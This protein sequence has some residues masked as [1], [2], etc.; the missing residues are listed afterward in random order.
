MVKNN[1][2]TNK[3]NLHVVQIASGD[4]WAG[5]EVM[6]YTLTKALHSNPNIKVTVILLNYDILEKKIRDCGID[7]Y[8]LDEAKLNSI[9]IFTQLNQIIKDIKPDVIH[10]HRLK[11]NIIGSIVAW[12]QNI[13]SIRTVHGAPE[14]KSPFYKVAKR[15]ITLLDRLTGRY[16][17][18]K[19]IAVSTDLAEKITPAFSKSKVHI[20]SNGIDIEALTHNQPIR[21]VN[22]NGPYRVGIAGRLMPVKRVDLFIESAKYLKQNNPEIN[23]SF[24]I[25]GDGPLQD[26]LNNQI[27]NLQAE[28]YI[29]LEGHCD[30]ISLALQQLDAL[31]MTS[32]HEGL[33]MILLEAMSLQTPIIAHAVGGIPNVLEDG[34]CGEL[35]KEHTPVAFAKTIAN[36]LKNYEHRA[37]LSKLAFECVNEKYSANITASSYLK[38]YEDIL[39][40]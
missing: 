40:L 16:L 34:K 25:Y 19:I 39:K 20:I 29:H 8:V 22:I 7:L 17:Q 30:N 36:L 1:N 5:A 9:K 2:Q 11:E 23:I 6:L 12:R 35:V 15:T 3:Q 18:Q 37:Q 27:A 33:P 13:P 26:E 31:V 24:H 38:I 21:E 32:D 28:N 4:L 10:T 14:H